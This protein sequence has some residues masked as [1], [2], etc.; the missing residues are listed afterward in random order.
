MQAYIVRFIHELTVR[1]F[2][3]MNEFGKKKKKNYFNYIGFY[4]DN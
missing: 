1:S 2:C 3:Q 4:I